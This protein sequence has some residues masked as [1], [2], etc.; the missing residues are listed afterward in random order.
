MALRGAGGEIKN[1][2]S[3]ALHLGRERM[4]SNSWA[5]GGL[6]AASCH[7]QSL[8]PLGTAA[9]DYVTASTG[10]HALAEAMFPLSAP[11]VRLVGPL[12]G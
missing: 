7:S 10:G 11:V 2:A 8:A 5:T 9:T 3:A 12:H 6:L 4:A 1:E